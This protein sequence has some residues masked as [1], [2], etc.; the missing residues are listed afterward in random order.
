MK[1]MNKV[2]IYDFDGTLTPFSLPKFEILEKC[3]L[4]KGALNPKFME[5]AKERM[6]DFDGDLYQA[7]FHTYFDIIKNSGHTL[8]DDNFTLGAGDVVYNKGVMEF[9]Q[10]LNQNNVENYLLSSGILVYLKKT[11]VAPFFKEMFATT[12]KYNEQGEAV[13]IDY[14]MSDKNKVDAIKEVTKTHS[15]KD[16]IYIGD[17]FTDYYAMEYVKN[18]GGNVIFVYND[19]HNKD[20]AAMKEKQVVDLFTEADFSHDSELNQY[21]RRLCKI[22]K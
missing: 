20:M 1:N 17:G 2:I 3:G 4:V 8:T 15:C 13:G 21:V 14:L 10:L 7:I 16:I 18:N 6:A 22:K 9:L 11:I 19:E 5:L 12:F